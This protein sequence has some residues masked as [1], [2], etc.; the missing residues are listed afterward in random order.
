[1]DSMIERYFPATMAVRRRFYT[2]R[3]LVFHPCRYPPASIAAEFRHASTHYPSW[4]CLGWPARCL[5]APSACTVA[6]ITLRKV[7]N[8]LSEEYSFSYGVP[9][10]FFLGGPSVPCE[11]LLR[12]FL[13]KVAKGAKKELK[14][15]YRNT[16]DLLEVLNIYIYS[17]ASLAYF[18]RDF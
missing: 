17:L 14:I 9:L 12:E 11:R 3:H 10:T 15:I 4:P 18:A 8:S 5:R 2:F 13:A 16:N 6:W 7:S 1:M